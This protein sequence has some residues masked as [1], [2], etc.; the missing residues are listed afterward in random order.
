MM[1]AEDEMGR[2]FST[3]GINEKC[4]KYI[5]GKPEE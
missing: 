2:A 4:E 3:H 1:R 5:V